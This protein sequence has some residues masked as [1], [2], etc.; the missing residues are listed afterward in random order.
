M[1][2]DSLV[3]VKKT[4]NGIFTEMRTRLYHRWPSSYSISSRGEAPLL[5]N[6]FAKHC[7]PFSVWI[8]LNKRGREMFEREA[9][10]MTQ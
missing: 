6:I 5:T 2:W 3:R 7:P 10:R 4:A 1:M 9:E 8:F